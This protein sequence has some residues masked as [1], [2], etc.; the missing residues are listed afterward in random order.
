MEQSPELI[1]IQEFLHACIPFDELSSDAIASL[2]AEIE[3]S[4][5]R[6][7]TVF[8]QQDLEAGL[9]ILRSGAAELRSENDL[10]LDRLAEGESFNLMG[11]NRE[12]PGIKA[13][14]IEDA[15][16]YTLPEKPYQKLRSEHRFFDR[17]FSSQRNRRVRRAARHEV[18]PHEMMRQV[19]SVMSQKVL[20][21]LPTSSIQ[22][23]AQ[24]M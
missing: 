14:L 24:N 23:T 19:R 2:L 13:I 12:Q 20:S 11:L 21:V 10:L 15:L 16:I 8:G 1:A 7:S 6:K 5:H 4:Y 22:A 18:S 17:F 9:R 3:V